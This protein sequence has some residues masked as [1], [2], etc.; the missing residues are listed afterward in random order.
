MPLA[1]HGALA[2]SVIAEAVRVQPLVGGGLMKESQPKS[3]SGYARRRRLDWR[4]TTEFVRRSKGRSFILARPAAVEPP[5]SGTS[6]L[7]QAGP[8]FWW[9]VE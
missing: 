6:A 5:P 1:H 9:N 4:L 2:H 3:Q 7:E 8:G